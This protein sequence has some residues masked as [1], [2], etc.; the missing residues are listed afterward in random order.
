[1]GIQNKQLKITGGRLCLDFL[2]TANWDRDGKIVEDK[3]SSEADLKMWC[4]LVGVDQV[5]LRFDDEGI[6]KIQSLRGELRHLFASV[7]QKG[8]LDYANLKVL[9]DIANDLPV[10]TLDIQKQSVVFDVEVSLRQILLFSAIS[11]LTYPAEISRVKM[12]GG[13]NCGWF[14]VD[15][16]K[17]GRR[18][19][20]SMELCGNRQKARRHYKRKQAADHIR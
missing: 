16:S 12:C 6:A 18:R 4:S 5:H 1:M 19:W 20:C 13:D 11:V 8:N 17:N 7:I 3:L 9:N 15:E 10:S 2:N 14:F